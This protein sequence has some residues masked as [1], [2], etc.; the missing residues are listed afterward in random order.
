MFNT[1]KKNE[2]YNKKQKQN[3]SLLYTVHVG[4]AAKIID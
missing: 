2:F 3:M 4:M 1:N